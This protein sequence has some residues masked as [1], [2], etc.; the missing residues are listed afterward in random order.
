MHHKQPPAFPSVPAQ[1]FTRR[2]ADRDA[3]IRG[4]LFPELDLPFADFENR[5]HLPQT[6]LTELMQTDF[7]CDELR[8]YLNIYPSDTNAQALYDEYKQK[9]AALKNE[10]LDAQTWAKAPWEV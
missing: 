3:I 4:T 10:V 7:V 6:P 8:L 2:Y 9:S 5:T 1:Q